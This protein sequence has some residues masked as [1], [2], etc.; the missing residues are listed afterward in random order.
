L[1]MAATFA[2]VCL[3]WVPFRADSLRQAGRLLSAMLGCGQR[4]GST[5]VVDAVVRQPWNLLLLVV[6]ASVIWGAPLQTRQ[7]VAVISVRRVLVC[8]VLLWLSI[9]QLTLQEQQPFIYFMF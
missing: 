9:L 5:L 8:L 7:F 2:V 3:T 6:A 1:L 4:D